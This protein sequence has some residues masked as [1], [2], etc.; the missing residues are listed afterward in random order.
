MATS[1]QTK[2]AEALSAISG[3]VEDKVVETFVDREVEK[4]STA[5]V[6]AIE[7]VSK[8]VD[9]LKK[10]DR[11]DNVVYDADGQVIESFSTFSKKRTDE[12]K[13]LNDQINKLTNA[14]NKALDSGDF[15]DVYKLASGANTGS[16]KSPASG[17]VADGA[18]E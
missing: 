2:I 9:D 4:R 7:K 11:P 12:R 10:I 17:P 16:D 18:S 15:G 6:M 5:M 13:K 14:I 3:E 1:V 8:F